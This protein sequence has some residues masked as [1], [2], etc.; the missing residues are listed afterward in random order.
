M[1]DLKEVNFSGFLNLFADNFCIALSD[2][3][4]S[5]ICNG[6]NHDLALFSDWCTS[7]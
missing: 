3:K 4:S 5:E 7:K 1:N 6:L 2:K